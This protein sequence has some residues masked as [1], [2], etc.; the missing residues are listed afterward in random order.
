MGQ[1]LRRQFLI[2]ASALLAAPLSRAQRARKVHRIGLPASFGPEARKAYVS[3]MRAYGWR[4]NENFVFVEAGLPFVPFDLALVDKSV[5][6]VV[7]KNSD[8]I[9]VASTS[10]ALAARRLTK[11]IPIVMI[12]SGYP[13]EAG[14]VRSLA[15]P[16]GNVTG[17]SIY[18]GTGVWGKLLELL[19]ETK[20][21]VKNISV[22]MAY[23]PPGFP[24]EEVEPMYTELREAA[25][26]LGVSIEIIEIYK[27]DEVPAA[28]ETAASKRVD[29]LLITAPILF[30]REWTRVVQFANERKL[31]TICDFAQ[32]VGDKRPGPLL[33]YGPSAQDL[34]RQAFSYVDRIL[35]G[36]S[37]GDLPIQ[38][39]SKFYLT[40]DQRTAKAIGLTLPPS[41]M[42]RADKVIELPLGE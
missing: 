40:A 38:R 2:A 1:V 26:N 34:R 42:L 37:P 19:R 41:I 20:P 22:L 3:A 36:A 31:P 18:A 12:A 9:F 35:K 17:N 21:T 23:V 16:G 14:L 33:A 24:A 39:P 8:L 32:V 27:S 4:E 10:Y 28:L 13:V 15:R 29:A 30:G 6:R 25:S 5:R 11:T 7:S